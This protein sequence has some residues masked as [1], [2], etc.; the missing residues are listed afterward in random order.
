[1]TTATKKSPE[2]EVNHTLIGKIAGDAKLKDIKVEAKGCKLNFE[3]LQLTP[4]QIEKLSRLI[5][6]EDILRVTMEQIQR[7]LPFETSKD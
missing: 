6:G 4:G 7:D 1:M 5:Q 3:N 2:A